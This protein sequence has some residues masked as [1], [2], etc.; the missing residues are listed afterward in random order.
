[1]DTLTT[2]VG[3]PNGA[4]DHIPLVHSGYNRFLSNTA[5]LD[6]V[7]LMWVKPIDRVKE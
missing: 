3:I 1:M 4:G 2:P 6:K 7:H 5:V